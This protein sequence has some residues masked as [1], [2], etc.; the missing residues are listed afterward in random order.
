MLAALAQFYRNRRNTIGFGKMRIGV[1]GHQQ[2]PGIDWSWVAYAVR[3]VLTKAHDVTKAYSSLAVGSDQI[4]ADAAIA[5]GI[6]VV[7]VLPLAGYE[8][9]FQGEGLAEYRRLLNQCEPIQ[10]TWDGDSEGAFFEAGKFVVEHSDTLVAIWDGAASEGLGGTADIIDY[11]SMR[12][13][14]I[15]HINP[16]AKKIRH[17]PRAGAMPRRF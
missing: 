17:Q 9:F 14:K 7:A 15:I 16:I 6:P 4:F 11:A 2:R 3:S 5:L 1:S 10:L 13:V 8:R 12:S